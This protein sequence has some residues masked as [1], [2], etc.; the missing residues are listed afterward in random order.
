VISLG[1]LQRAG[2]PKSTAEYLMHL[3]NTGQLDIG[4]P[5]VSFPALWMVVQ[6][7][8]DAVQRFASAP[9][10]YA[11]TFSRVLTALAHRKLNSELS[12][13]DAAQ[14]AAPFIEDTLWNYA[15]DMQGRM[16]S[17]RGVAEPGYPTH[18]AVHDLHLAAGSAALSRYARGAVCE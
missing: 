11:E 8:P 17:K 16:F 10:Y 7:A 13:Y 5:A 1:A 9:G 2:I 18:D 12:S 14:A 3:A 6:R 4:G 15:Q